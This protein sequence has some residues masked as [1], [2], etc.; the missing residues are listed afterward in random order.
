MVDK[1]KLLTQRAPTDFNNLL[2]LLLKFDCNETKFSVEHESKK[3]SIFD[4]QSYQKWIE[5]SSFKGLNI[6]L[7]KNFDKSQIK[8]KT[9]QK[10]CPEIIIAETPQKRGRGK[11][12]EEKKISNKNQMKSKTPEKQNLAAILSDLPQKRGRSKDKEGTPKK[13]VKTKKKGKISDEKVI[14][15]NKNT[16]T[17]IKDSKSPK[18]RTLSTPAKN[19]NTPK[20]IKDSKSPKI[21][22]LS[23]PAKNS[24]TGG[25]IIG[26]PNM[27][28]SIS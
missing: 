26:T 4:Q 16:P 12:K 22:S 14:E 13:I 1:Q 20:I 15:S 24:K 23:T 6:I 27:M 18:T 17:T 11:D 21:R 25:K 2:K 9:P 8:T 7:K 3:G 5:N 28:S 19:S 10:S